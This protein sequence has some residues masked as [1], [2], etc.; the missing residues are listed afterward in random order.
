M[1]GGVK[2]S[3]S[4]LKML[5]GDRILKTDVKI[6]KPTVTKKVNKKRNTTFKKIDV[7]TD[8]KRAISKLI[9]TDQEPNDFLFKIIRLNKKL[10]KYPRDSKEKNSK[11][12]DKL[13]LS[14]AETL[15]YEFRRDSNINYNSNNS[16]STQNEM[17]EEEDV[18]ND[19]Y[20]LLRTLNKT[21]ENVLLSDDEEYKIEISETIKNVLSAVYMNIY[22]ERED[23]NV[24][25]LSRMMSGTMF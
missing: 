24:N 17:V 12:V 22:G 23:K 21:L 15:Y 4:V 11:F 9:T 1:E 7:R 2:Y 25:E 3:P 13:I 5:K 6:F 19:P 14:L 10:L 8:F 20:T 18:W 16:N